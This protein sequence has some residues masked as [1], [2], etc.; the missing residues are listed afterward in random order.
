MQSP[1]LQLC[2]IS[3]LAFA[4]AASCLAQ[5]DQTLEEVVVTAQ[6]RDRPESAVTASTTVLRAAVLQNAGQQH[7]ADVLALVP[8]LNWAAGSS[9]PR[10]FQL[11]GIGELEQW[12]GAPNPSVGFLIDDVDFSGVG[13][14]ATLFDIEQVEVL[15]GP[16]GVAYGANA[17]AGLISI[18]S[19]APTEHFEA[20]LQAD[21][22]DYGLH[23]LGGVVSG[24]LGESLDGVY[25]VAAQRQRSDGF[26]ENDYLGRDDTNGYD[27]TTL[28]AR[29]RLAVGND[30]TANLATFWVDTDNGYDAFSIDN[31][32]TTLSDQPGRDAQR[33][34]GA[35]LRFDYAGW[36]SAAL[37]AVSAVA[38]S[39]SNYSFDGDWGND[40]SWGASGPY[41]F[42]QAF[43]RQR[44][45]ISQ[46]LRITSA[47]SAP[48]D[49]TV[50]VYALRLTED[51]T[52]LDRY[53]GTT[54]RDLTSEY[55]ATNVALYG[56]LATELATA[57]TVSA[58][59]RLEHR[60]ASY[61]DSDGESVAPDE[62]L[63]G[64]SLTVR[65]LLSTNHSVYATVGRGYKAG[66]FN[67]G[68][69]IPAA[70]RQFTAEYLDS[71]ELGLRTRSVDG[72][73]SGALALFSMLRRDQQVENSTQLTPGDP[74]TFVY[75][76]DNAA[77]GRNQGL[78]GSFD[79]RVT[80]RWSIDGSLGLLR[81][82][83]R[84]YV[85]AGRDLAGREQPHAPGYQY[86]LAAEYRHPHGWFVRTDVAGRD[87]FYFS[88]SHDQ[89]S[90]P[91][92][93]TNLKLGYAGLAATVEFWVRNVFDVEYSQ[94]GFF[95]GNEPPDFP[96]KRYTQAGDPRQLG[97]TVR[98]VWQ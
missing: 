55:R 37:R 90:E 46:D 11:R 63:W 30:L 35:A 70:Q 85:N 83:Y 3:A 12:Q 59:V 81:A 20:R 92:T 80:P 60:A 58:G 76:T 94:R 44:L 27:E 31:S 87:A 49:W 67:I 75:F 33:S 19:R 1:I 28:R 10:Y 45:T 9:R 56:E 88:A 57:T 62:T 25:R 98:Y 66:G 42:T 51:G 40:L 91:Y 22:G 26:R 4:P 74:L 6:L 39:R 54:L 8:N 52:Q 77:R 69:V 15:R 79:W 95:F 68:A 78:E 96:E 32:R 21:A 36:Q 89:R 7:L 71:V 14:P 24:P 73:L 2:F 43:A 18:R 65:R 82:I 16:Q 48:L 61:H 29:L 97:V 86:S 93:L 84:E 53:N 38:D 13:M 50:G 23:G 64:G 41:D 72:R 47:E 17:L 5:A 34:R